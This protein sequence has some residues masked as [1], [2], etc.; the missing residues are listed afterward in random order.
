VEL[1]E[2]DGLIVLFHK[3]SLSPTISY[4]FDHLEKYLLF[5]Q[6]SLKNYIL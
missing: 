1:K 3:V 2:I 6:Y 4:K 5:L